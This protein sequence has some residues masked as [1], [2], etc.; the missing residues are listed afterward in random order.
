LNTLLMLISRS[1]NE[2]DEMM[3]VLDENDAA[4]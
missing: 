4:Q 2:W 3:D 1:K